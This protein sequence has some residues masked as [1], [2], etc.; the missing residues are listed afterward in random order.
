MISMYQLFRSEIWE[1]IFYFFIHIMFHIQLTNPAYLQHKYLYNAFRFLYPHSF[2]TQSVPTS[3][4]FRT[5]TII[6]S[7]LCTLH[8][9]LLLF[10]LFSIHWSI[11][12]QICICLYT[13]LALRSHE[14][15]CGKT[16]TSTGI[17]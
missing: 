14:P 4:A 6:F 7:Q 13:S 11:I 17:C 3:F 1:V 9:F 10:D 15:K 5:I 16:Q 8:Q 2:H 12:L